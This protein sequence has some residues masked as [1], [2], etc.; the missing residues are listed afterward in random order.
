[1]LAAS[2]DH[3]VWVLTRQNNLALLEQFIEDH[4]NRQRIHLEGI[5][6]STFQR[7]LKKASIGGMHWYYDRWQV[8]VGKRALELDHQIG[9]D[10]VHH[11]TF[12][13]YWTR[14][15]VAV[16]DKP[17]VWG[18][19]GGAVDVPVRMWGIL[20]WRG[21]RSE[22]TRRAVR[23]GMLARPTVRFARQR[24]NVVLAQN[25]E[26]GGLFVGRETHVLPNA[27]VAADP[28]LVREGASVENVLAFV[29]RLIPWKGVLLALMTLRLL[30][31]IDCKLLI[32]G[33]GPDRGRIERKI[34]EWGLANRVQLL[35]MLPR[36]EALAHVGQ[37]SL[38]LHPA[39]KE[40]AGLAVVEALVLG[41]PVVCLDHGGPSGL[42]RYWPDTLCFTV[43]IRSPAHTAEGLAQA[44]RSIMQQPSGETH[45]PVLPAIDYGTEVLRAYDRARQLGHRQT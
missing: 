34:E 30:E 4:P 38:L 2:V 40:E 33:D 15:G 21:A 7:S 14:A 10:V 28:S 22:A 16:V 20:G 42:A 43:P 36:D 32:I 45:G 26:T 31:D 23:V 44:V 17:F 8:A 39:L 1:M 9:F 27:L 5:D 11:V 41:T 35:G 24:A 3:D 13:N 18:P 19:I 25:S 6:L 37:A 12:A 29:G